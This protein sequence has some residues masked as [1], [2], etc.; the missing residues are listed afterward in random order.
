MVFVVYRDLDCLYE[1]L[2]HFDSREEAEAYA[3]EVIRE[4]ECEGFSAQAV[5]VEEEDC[6][7][8]YESW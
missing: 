6:E 4:D 2:D 5:V 7:P 1:P 3:R 8:D